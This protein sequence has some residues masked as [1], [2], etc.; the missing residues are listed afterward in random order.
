VLDAD[1]RD[2]L[3]ACFEARLRQREMLPLIAAAMGVPEP[4]VFYEWAIRRC[5]QDEIP[6]TPWLL[7]F[8]GLECDLRNRDDGR[9]IRYDFGPRGSVDCVTPY[10]VL[11][12]IM[13]SKAPWREFPSL[14]KRFAAKG[15][16]Y[17]YLSGDLAKIM[18]AWERLERVGCF[19]P[20]DPALVSLEAQH[21]I[22]TP[23]GSRRLQFPADTSQ[24]LWMDV[25]VAA[26]PVLTPRAE[27]LIDS[28]PHPPR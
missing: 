24:E 17:D 12:F 3:S 27:E 5:S 10:G 2:L 7:Q 21:T 22:V 16:P 6:N 14:R 8:H 19:A 28:P 9:F 15:P 4:Q 26:L 1:D 25:V 23:D 11:Q 18:S 13:T 20:A